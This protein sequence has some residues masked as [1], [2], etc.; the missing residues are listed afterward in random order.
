MCAQDWRQCPQ[1][2]ALC[3]QVLASIAVSRCDARAVVALGEFAGALHRHVTVLEHDELVALAARAELTALCGRLRDLLFQ[4]YWRAAPCRAR[5]RLRVLLENLVDR[6]ASRTFLP[7]RFWP[8]EGLSVAALIA[9]PIDDAGADEAADELDVRQRAMRSV[10]RHA[11]FC[12]AFR[13]RVGVLQRELERAHARHPVRRFADFGF[14]H[15]DLQ[16]HRA[17][18]FEDAFEQLR[19]LPPDNWRCRFRVH[20]INAMGVP[21][22]GIDGGGLFKEF[23]LQSE[24][25]G[26]CASLT[27][28]CAAVQAA[29]GSDYALFVETSATA[30]SR[31]LYPNPDAALATDQPDR[32]CACGCLVSLIGVVERRFEF[33]GALLGKCI[34]EQIL[35]DLPFASF[36][37]GRLLGQYF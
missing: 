3:C 14:G 23:L 36:F 6:D 17:S 1:Q 10:L 18:V 28:A 4:L 29:F 37:L 21:E 35:V 13:E 7:P 16:I 34:Y 5:R 27:R 20:M 26:A 11:P 9:R 24:R 30:G 8:I 12:V 32:M 2:C 25:V 15:V 22:M 31:G 33:L 19:A